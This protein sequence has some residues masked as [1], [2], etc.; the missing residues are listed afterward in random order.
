[1]T[2]HGWLLALLVT[3]GAPGALRV[4]GAGIVTSSA[5][6]TLSSPQAALPPSGPDTAAASVAVARTMVTPP[7]EVR[8]WQTGLL[9]PDRLQH[10]SLSMTSAVATGVVSRSPA[11]GMLGALALGLAKEL[12]DRHRTGFDP[13]DL[14][15]DAMGAAAGTAAAAALDR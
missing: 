13:I 9:R 10:A 12:W 1:M 14:V 8:A 15:A 3:C 5:P 2:G 11:S 6:D 7:A 4:P